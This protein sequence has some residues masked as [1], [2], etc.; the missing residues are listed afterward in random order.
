MNITPAML[1]NLYATI[2]CCHPFTKWNMPLPEEIK[3]EVIEDPSAYA[4]YTYDEGEEYAHKIQ[5]SRALCGH[6]MTVLRSLCHEAVHM[7][8]W[9][10]SRERW[11]HHDKVFKMRCKAVADEFGLDPLEL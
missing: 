4:Y 8:R 9:A 3:F 6:F 5:I 11:N 10:H 1:R 2:Y 7:S